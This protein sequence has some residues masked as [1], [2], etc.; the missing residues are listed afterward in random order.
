MKMKMK[1][2]RIVKS[3]CLFVALLLAVLFVTSGCDEILINTVPSWA[4]GNWSIT[5]PIIFNQVTAV[6]ITSKEFIPR[7]GFSL[8]SFLSGNAE[9]KDVTLVTNNEVIF[10][11]FKVTKGKSSN[12]IE[13]GLLVGDTITLYRKQQ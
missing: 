10:D 4:R 9:K 6:E 7:E 8:I 1:N 3:T 5:P 12:E 11:L 2:K 13:L